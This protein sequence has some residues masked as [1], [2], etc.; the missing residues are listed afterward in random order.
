MRIQCQKCHGEY[1]ESFFRRNSIR[2]TR[3]PN[4]RKA[5]CRG[6]E[7]TD[8]DKDKSKDRFVAKARST[9]SRHQT[10]LGLRLKDYGWNVPDMAHDAE[11]AFKNGCPYCRR[12]F[13][14]MSGLPDL[15]LDIINPA[16]KPFYKVNTKWVCGTCNK[17]KQ[18]Y[19]ADEWGEN[20][21]NWQEWREWQE[22]RQKLK[23]A[24]LPLFENF[25]P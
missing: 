2:H 18:Q 5:I 21:Q 1:L 19:G 7:Q 9:L 8:R 24:G 12:P 13:L 16:N 3:V 25:R 20:Q 22:K 14:S 6:C 23:W 17:Q 11:H 4:Y 10:R 15:T